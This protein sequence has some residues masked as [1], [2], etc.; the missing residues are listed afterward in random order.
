M[1]KVRSI[2]INLN[3]LISNVASVKSMEIGLLKPLFVERIIM[4]VNIMIF[5]SAFRL[6]LAL[7]E[8][9][10]DGK[11]VM[12]KFILSWPLRF[13]PGYIGYIMVLYLMPFFIYGTYKDI[14][15]AFKLNCDLNGW[16]IFAFMSN[17]DHFPDQCMIIAWFNSVN[18]QLSII[19]CLI[20]F[21]LVKNQKLGLLIAI[22]QIIFIIIFE[23]WRF[24]HYNLSPFLTIISYDM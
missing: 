22:S 18:F 19:H 6:F 7:Y 17:Y 20:M 15:D 1:I 8:P 11:N 16:K 23:G 13:Y 14:F 5:F 12:T 3:N 4:G 2:V 21:V 24:I 9:L 10:K